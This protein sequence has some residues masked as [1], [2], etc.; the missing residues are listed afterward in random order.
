MISSNLLLERTETPLLNISNM[1]VNE[2]F[3]V[4]GIRFL[5]EFNREFDNSNKILYKAIY[6]TQDLN[7]INESF[8]D[9][10]NSVKKIINKFLEFIKSIFNRF[11]AQFNK[12]IGNDKYIIKHQDQFKKFN[13]D[14]EFNMDLFKYTIDPN[15]PQLSAYDDYM[16]DITDFKTNYDRI[17]N[18]LKTDSNSNDKSYTEEILKKMYK[19][20]IDEH[21]ESW[22]DNFRGKVLNM[23]NVGISKED[24]GTELFE[25]FRNGE[26]VKEDTRVDSTIVFESLNTFKNYS[27]TI[28]TI[29]KNKRTLEKEYKNIKDNISK[30]KGDKIELDNDNTITLSNEK[31]KNQAE[32]FFKAK[33]NQIQTMCN[34]HVMA[35]TAKLDAVKEQYKQDKDILYK[36]IKLIYKKGEK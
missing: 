19:D 3:F 12:I 34:I 8:S 13:M 5:N 9:F 27:K 22:Y 25:L 18:G 32:L 15:V 1:N 17:E 31:E 26:S 16:S 23:T 7:V 6:E 35:F 2:C 10:T 14:H 21:D 4:T 33:A 20:T 29:E 30:I 28:S 36:A 11:I 24:Y